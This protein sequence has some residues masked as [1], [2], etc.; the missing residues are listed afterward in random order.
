MTSSIIRE[1]LSTGRSV[2]SVVLLHCKLD[3]VIVSMIGTHIYL[4]SMSF[5][6]EWKAGMI[7]KTIKAIIL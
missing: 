7:L 1:V 4:N 5:F 2:S 3:Y 6:N